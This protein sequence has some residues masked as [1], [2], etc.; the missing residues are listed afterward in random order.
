MTAEQWCYQSP[1]ALELPVSAIKL[2]LAREARSASGVRY[3]PCR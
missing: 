3:S 2:T 1:A